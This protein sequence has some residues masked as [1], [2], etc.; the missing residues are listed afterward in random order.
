[1]R[2]EQEINQL[3]RDIDEWH[4]QI[5]DRRRNR[6]CATDAA[7]YGLY[8]SEIRRLHEEIDHA[9]EYSNDIYQ[10]IEQLH[11]QDEE[12]QRYLDEVAAE[13]MATALA[14]NQGR[15]EGLGEDQAHLAE[16]QGEAEDAKALYEQY[17]PAAEADR[18]EDWTEDLAIQYEEAFY[19]L[20]AEVKRLEKAVDE[21][22]KMKDEVDRVLQEQR[23]QAQEKF[24]DINGEWE[25]IKDDYFNAKANFEEARLYSGT[26]QQ[27][28]DQ[29]RDDIMN[30]E[31]AYW[32]A[33]PIIY[34]YKAEEQRAKAQSEDMK[35]VFDARETKEGDAVNELVQYKT[36]L[37]AAI[38]VANT[39]KASWES[40]K[41]TLA[42]KQA[43]LKAK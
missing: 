13:Q 17:N 1:L 4:R 22:Q 31:R 5:A 39:E 25:R 26:D 32:D 38:G 7:T 23:D 37:D 8:D 28:L 30:A 40:L 20:Q 15:I 3:Y 21:T 10:Y 11:Q 9:H 12:H 43:D 33:Q 36:P 24:N 27:Y 14:E 41:T 6:E 35:A 16:R 29:L 2:A 34:E 18:P 19:D 42:E